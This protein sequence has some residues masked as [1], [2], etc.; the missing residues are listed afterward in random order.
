MAALEMY[1][2]LSA[3]EVDADPESTA[4]AKAMAATSIKAPAGET[5]PSPFDDGVQGQGRS[6]EPVSPVGHVH[7][8]LE[9][10]NFGPLG[11]SSANLPAPMRPSALSD[12][13]YEEKKPVERVSLS[14]FSDYES[15]DEETHKTNAASSS[16]RH[17]VTVS[18]NEEEP[19]APSASGSGKA[20]LVD[21]DPFADPFADYR[22]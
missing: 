14:D 22:K 5:L 17:Y 11:N 10:L 4:L 9:D 6:S 2:R 1:D 20:K 15:S 18:D 3:S 13:G 8:D 7:P 19:T 12:D 16:K 21:V